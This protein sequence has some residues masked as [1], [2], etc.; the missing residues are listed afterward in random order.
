MYFKK[1]PNLIYDFNIN[2]QTEY[3]RVKDI[4]RNVRFRQQ[5]LESITLYD[6][7][8][9]VDGETPEV[10]AEKVYGNANYHW[11]VMLANQRYDYRTDFPLSQI[12]LDKYIEEKY[13]A[14]ADGIHHW[15]DAEGIIQAST[16]S[17]AVSVS[18][19]QYEERV[20]EE[21][22]R[23]KLPSKNVIAKILKEYKELI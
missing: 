20:N 13:G 2:G 18:N 15:E 5:V 16:V 22:R 9:I 12:S 4:T 17:G 19:R 3:R 10:I 6:E 21:K 8:D 23:I 1:F 14:E 11:I 7:Y